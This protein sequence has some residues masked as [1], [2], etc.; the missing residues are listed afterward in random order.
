MFHIQLELSIP[1]VIDRIY[2][3]FWTGFSSKNITILSYL[4]EKIKKIYADIARIIY[5][6]ISEYKINK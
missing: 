5:N 4:I 2:K 1:K 6:N 3:I